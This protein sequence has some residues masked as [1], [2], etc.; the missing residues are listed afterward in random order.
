M[1]EEKELILIRGIPGSGKSTFAKL[2]LKKEWFHHE[3]DD[4]FMLGGFYDFKREQLPFAHRWNIERTEGEMSKGHSGIV[5]NTLITHKEMKPYI[6]L[7]L[8]YGYKVSII[9]MGTQFV[10]V[11]GVPE[12]TIKR[13]K[14]EWED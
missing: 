13:M 9:K 10:S 7:A 12:E 3:T 6:S 1:S 5:S 4:F 11:H 2:I 14:D 8:K